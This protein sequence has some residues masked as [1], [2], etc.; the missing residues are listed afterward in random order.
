VVDPTVAGFAVDTDDGE[1][2]VDGT[3]GGMLARERPELAIEVLRA[4]EA[5][6]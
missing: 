2:T 4:W 6:R 5:G 3:L 1:M